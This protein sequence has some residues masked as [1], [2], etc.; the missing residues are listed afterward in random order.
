MILP[1]WNMFNISKPK[2]FLWTLWNHAVHSEISGSY[3]RPR[4]RACKSIGCGW[5]KECY[6]YHVVDRIMLIKSQKNKPIKHSLST[7][8]MYSLSRHLRFSQGWLKWVAAYG[9]TAIS[10]PF[11]VAVSWKSVF[12]PSLIKQFW[13]A[14]TTSAVF[15]LLITHSPPVCLNKPS[16]SRDEAVVRALASHQLA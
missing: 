14:Q 13:H 5:I 3:C 9:Y 8:P 4:S 2:C 1:L 12:K 16:G 11:I 7:T 6:F 15:S 10:R